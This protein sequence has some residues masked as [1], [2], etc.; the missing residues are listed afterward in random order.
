MGSP[1]HH[2]ELQKFSSEQMIVML[3]GLVNIYTYADYLVT[4]RDNYQIMQA[5]WVMRLCGNHVNTLKEENL[6]KIIHIEF[7]PFAEW[8]KD[9][10]Y[11][12]PGTGTK[13]YLGKLVEKHFDKLEINVPRC[14]DLLFFY[15]SFNTQRRLID[16]YFDGLST[17]DLQ[18]K[19]HLKLNKRSNVVFYIWSGGVACGH[20]ILNSITAGQVNGILPDPLSS[21]PVVPQ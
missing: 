6:Y 19:T 5:Y 4:P 8:N 21:S 20:I 12:R 15:R 14:L 2:L 9:T 17:T 3:G 7:C 10:C 11:V 16:R 18:N 1:C 13:I